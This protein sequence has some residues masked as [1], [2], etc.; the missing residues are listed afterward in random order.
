MVLA[1]AR[2]EAGMRYIIPICAPSADLIPLS[3]NHC[4]SPGAQTPG[5][6]SSRPPVTR[7]RRKS[8]VHDREFLKNA[9]RQGACGNPDHIAAPAGEADPTEQRSGRRERQTST[10]MLVGFARR[11]RS[12]A[13]PLPRRR[14]PWRR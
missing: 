2:L 14:R 7:L 5:T 6:I 4:E 11:V 3:L 9:Q 12:S 13:A 10:P 1:F 8:G